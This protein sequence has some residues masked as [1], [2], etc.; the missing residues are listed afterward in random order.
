MGGHARLLIGERLLEPDPVGGQPAGY[1][2]DVHMM[3]MF[4]GAR[5]RTEPEFRD[6]LAS[7]G[8]AFERSISTASAFSI[9]EAV[10]R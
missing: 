8:F 9:I 6:L 5:E 10:P 2:L 3:A 1:L 4:D 7:S